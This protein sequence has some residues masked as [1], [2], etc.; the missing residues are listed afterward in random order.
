VTE[1]ERKK[2]EMTMTH[3]P[4]PWSIDRG[5]G[6]E[7]LIMAEDLHIATIHRPSEG[8]WTRGNARLIAAAPEL[9]AVADAP[10]ITKVG[11]TLYFG[12]WDEGGC[13]SVAIPAEMVGFVERWDAKR[14]AA[15]AKAKETE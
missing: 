3:A 5:A 12:L 1:R 9:L 15:V 10:R 14:T 8:Y 4:G 7:R 2:G 11:K 13:W 6:H